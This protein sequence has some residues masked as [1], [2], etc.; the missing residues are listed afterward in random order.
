MS[1]LL[2]FPS[3]LV[4]Y[5]C[6]FLVADDVFSLM[7]C[8]SQSFNRKLTHSVRSIRLFPSDEMMNAKWLFSLPQ[9]HLIWIISFQRP[10]STNVY[11][12]SQPSNA[13]MR[14]NSLQTLVFDFANSFH[15][16]PESGGSGITALAPNLLHLKLKRA[17]TLISKD[18]LSNLPPMLQT[19]SLCPNHHFDDVAFLTAEDLTSLPQSITHLDLEAVSVSFASFDFA[20]QSLF[21]PQLTSLRLHNAGDPEILYHLPPTLVNLDL[22]LEHDKITTS[23]QPSTSL[24]LPKSLRKLR[25]GCWTR[26]LL[27]DTGPAGILFH[28]CY[29]GP[30]HPELEKCVQSHDS[31]RQ[32]FKKTGNFESNVTDGMEQD[33]NDVDSI[34]V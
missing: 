8:G 29:D 24:C 34:F 26:S 3:D 7:T 25:F 1:T 13:L 27:L 5:L 10:F 20:H 21:P 32:W 28:W 6:E 19:L 12:G 9:V 14:C 30:M 16:L 15:F 11:L 22:F 18:M 31:T 17:Q 23:C 4:S 33:T 2:A